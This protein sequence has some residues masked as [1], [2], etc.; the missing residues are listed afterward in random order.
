[1]FQQG[2]AVHM[3][4]RLKV[5]EN[6]FQIAYLVILA[7]QTHSLVHS[8]PKLPNSKLSQSDTSVSDPRY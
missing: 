3:Q 1:M 5:S 8:L 4:M 6:C 2:A 7:Q